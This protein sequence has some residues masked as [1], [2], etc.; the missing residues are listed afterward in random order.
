MR[1]AKERSP[2]MIAARLGIDQY[3]SRLR[4]ARTGWYPK[5]E[6]SGFGTALPELK[7][8][9][10]GATP[11]QDYDFTR[12]GPLVVGSVSL[13]QTVYTFGKLSALKD[14]ARQ[15]IDI[16]AATVRAAEDEAAYQV[17]RVWWGMVLAADLH[18]MVA[19]AKRL[20]DEQRQ[21]VEKARDADDGNFNQADLLKLNVFAADI[22]NKIRQFERNRAQADD[23]MRLALNLESDVPV[24][25]AGELTAV[26][27]PPV[28]VEALEALAL[29]NAPRLLAQRKGVQARL[30]QAELA[31]NQ[32][33]PDIVFVARY[34][35][36]YAPTRTENTDS[37]ATNPTNTATS[38]VGLV[39]RWT[40]D[41]WRQ[42]EK[43]D[44]ADLD[45][46]QTSLQERYESKKLAMDVRQMFREMTDA[47]AMIDVQERAYKSARGWLNAES[48]AYEDGIQEFTEVLRAMEAYSTKRLAFAESVYTYNLA[49]AALSRAVGMDLTTL[50]AT[51]TPAA[52]R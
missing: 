10:S 35:Y 27:V 37:L 47:R 44:Q 25:A 28:P 9:H 19:D 17:A 4:E 5:F 20:L 38:G 30:V 7:P 6:V 22:E 8:G 48:Q 26:Y 18:D 49:V 24:E 16:A 3:E 43:I 34:A 31:R 50:Q 51:P 45:A 15:G 32:L 1:L 40:L 2:L 33:W 41:L 21:K 13:A 52:L 23:G 39:L 11:L 36:T 14:L 29:A 46:R 42:L 12:L